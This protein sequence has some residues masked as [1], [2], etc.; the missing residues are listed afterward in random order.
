MVAGEASGDNLGA[1][2]IRALRERNPDIE[3]CGVAGPR[4]QAEGCA[5]WFDCEELAVMGIT[6]VVRHLPRL[7]RL[8]KTLLQRF[9][10]EPPD[11]FVGIDAPDFN[12]GLE[13]RLRIR[14]IRTVQYV[15]PSVWA[16]RRGRMKKIRRATDCVLCL[17]PFETAF[18]ESQQHPAVFVGHPLADEIP[19]DSPRA[20]ARANLGL[21]PADLLL[22]VLPGSRQGEV[23][24]IG[25]VFAQTI[26]LLASRFPVLEFVAPMVSEVTGDM[27]RQQLDRHAPGVRVQILDGSAQPAM[28]AADAVLMASGTAVL[29]ALLIGRPHVVAYRIAPATAALLRSLKLMHAPFYSLSN[30]LAGR[31][32]VPEFIQERATPEALCDA[33]GR[34]LAPGA[35]AEALRA[36]FREIHLALRKDASRRAASAVLDVAG[37]ST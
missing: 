22:A 32:L 2:L 12:L 20:P 11:V 6:E 19:M 25:P 7:V 28:V 26:A 35:D 5:A 23:A 31:E 1:G 27:F 30:L 18:Y 33:I 36:S 14:G 16:W 8:R 10:A 34:Q 24:R 37:G 21:A 3:F 29:E 17:L 4:M 9:A 15:S 13:Q